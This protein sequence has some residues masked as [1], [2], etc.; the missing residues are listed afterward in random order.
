MVRRVLLGCLGLP[1]ALTICLLPVTGCTGSRFGSEL[2][3][4]PKPL[5]ISNADGK[6]MCLP[7]SGPFSIALPK[8]THEAGLEGTADSGASAEGSGTAMATATVTQAGTAVG[9]FQLGHAFENDT[10]QQND[11]DF[12]VRFHY[13]FD[14]AATP[15]SGHPDADVGLKLYA[16]DE[17]GRLLRDQ[18]LL[19]HSTES[20]PA[21]G[22][23]DQSRQFTLTLGPGESVSVFVAGQ[24]KIEIRE[25]RSAH[26]SLKLTNL[27]MEVTR[28]PA[29][30]VGSSEHEQ[31]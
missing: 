27:Q 9:S 4:R 12:T 15:E 22:E 7:D 31:K 10:D 5:P 16:R 17:R 21:A 11:V 18:T 29:P 20:G 28:R 8:V 26:G 25:G 14:A 23:S 6:A 1:L 30:A 3:A 19:T 2:A 13:A 24:V